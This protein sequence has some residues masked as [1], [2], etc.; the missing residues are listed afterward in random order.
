M[1]REK[2]ND[3]T[4]DKVSKSVWF[5]FNDQSGYMVYDILKCKNPDNGLE[6]QWEIRIWDSIPRQI[7][8]SSL[9]LLE[10]ALREN[11]K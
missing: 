8:I 6:R 11:I 2:I 3:K 9:N 7:L 4:W 10:N 5:T 1:L